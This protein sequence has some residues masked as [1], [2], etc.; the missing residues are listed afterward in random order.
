MKH[1]KSY[2]IFESKNMNDFMSVIYD[3]RDKCIEFNDGGCTCKISPDDEIRLNLLRLQFNGSLTSTNLVFK[4]NID[5]NKIQYNKDLVSNLNS[6]PNWF[7]DQCLEIES[8][9]NS[10]GFKTLPS[11]RR[12]TD[13]EHFDSID[14]LSE[15]TGLF[16]EV[17]LLFRKIGE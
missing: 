14:E 2:K 1:L 17:Q 9:M 15:A 16:R 6:L 10:Y 5:V 12:P 11:I 7:I 8:M 3:L 13:W 4:L